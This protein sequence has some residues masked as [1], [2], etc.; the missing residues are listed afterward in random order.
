MYCDSST[1]V[2]SVMKRVVLRFPSQ[3]FLFE[4]DE[5]QINL[6]LLCTLDNEIN[7]YHHPLGPFALRPVQS[8]SRY[9]NSLWDMSLDENEYLSHEIPSLFLNTQSVFLP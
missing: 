3:T 9:L 6:D 4:D 5:Y 8:S 2:R 1:Q 7:E